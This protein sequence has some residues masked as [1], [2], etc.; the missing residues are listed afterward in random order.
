MCFIF[1]NYRS[2]GTLVTNNDKKMQYYFNGIALDLMLK[3]RLSGISLSSFGR[4]LLRISLSSSVPRLVSAFQLHSG[5]PT[6]FELIRFGYAKSRK[7]ASSRDT[8]IETTS[9]PISG[10]PGRQAYVVG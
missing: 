1:E 5:L 3:S 7:M 4:L 2:S 8:G 10:M 6:S 9:L